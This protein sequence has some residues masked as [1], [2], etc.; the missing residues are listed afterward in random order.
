MLYGRLDVYWPDGPVESHRLDKPTL[1]VGRSSGNDIVLD[2]T[3]VS[4]YHITLTF[5][6]QQVLLSDLQSVNGTYVDGVRLDANTPFALRGGE[7]IQIGDIRLIYYPPA[8]VTSPLSDTTQRIT[9]SQ[10]TY[11]VE[12]EG[13][14]MAVAPGAHVQATLKVENLGGSTDTY[15]VE[16]EGLPKGWARL[17]RVEMEVEPGEQAQAVIS[18]KP[19]RRSESAPGEYRATIRVRS[20]LQP[21]QT[22]EVPT[23]FHVLPFSGFGMALGSEHVDSNGLLKL[24]V[25]NQ[26]NAPLALS[27][28]GVV[29]SQALRFQFPTSGL[30]LAPGERQT[31]T[32]VVKPRHHRFF[33]AERRYEFAVSARAQDASGFVASVP[34]FYHE[35]ATLPAWVPVIGVPL[36]A[37]G[38]LLL[39][40]LVFLLLGRDG[41][42]DD[43]T[44]ASPPQILTFTASSSSVSIGE[45]AEFNWSVA[46]AEQ[47]TLTVQHGDNQQEMEFG[48]DQ[49]TYTQL[50][51]E[52]GQ[53][54]VVLTAHNGDNQSDQSLT[55]QVVPRVTLAVDTKGVSRFVLYV[56]YPLDVSWDVVGAAEV[57]GGYNISLTLDSATESITLLSAPV[58]LAGS[59]TIQ[60]VPRDE[61]G[62]WLFTLTAT[63]PDGVINR[64]TQKVAADEVVRS[65]CELS[66]EQTILRKGPGTNYEAIIP[67]IERP[68]EG[69]FPLPMIGR[70]EQG[71]WL[72]AS[73]GAG[74]N[75]VRGWVPRQDF[76]CSDFDPAQLV[77]VTDYPPPPA[78]PTPAPT[79]TRRIPPTI[80]ITPTFPLLTPTRLPMGTRA[81]Q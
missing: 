44:T 60:F 17:D 72:Q 23:V 64:Q 69:S 7:E 41:D 6:N 51:Q 22:T 18:F 73:Y 49:H 35:K 55:L 27:L 1:A 61:Q 65:L 26:G 50:F 46:N 33:G 40:G 77:V 38:A 32:S 58:A 21:T 75:P 66:A 45:N 70:N 30:V 28:F 71:D 79:A 4:R 10:S 34:G 37:L 2:T 25:H 16:V 56:E 52:A 59:Q 67:P 47:V 42:D 24:Y 63:G 5:K 62:D 68:T 11:K 3:A 8:E 13:P 12:F 14:E 20:K 57:P 54:T 53:Y 81:S 36:I 76:I 29:P 48:P 39:V 80:T 78:T 9:L 74:E 15:G 31:L 19:L 43:N